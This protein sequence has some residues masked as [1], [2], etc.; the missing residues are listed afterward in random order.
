[1]NTPPDPV[2]QALTRSAMASDLS[3][4]C[5]NLCLAL[6][7]RPDVLQF[8]HILEKAHGDKWAE[9]SEH[10]REI[11][12]TNFLA[13]LNECQR[14]GISPIV[15]VDLPE[16]ERPLPPQIFGR[17]SVTIHK[18]KDSG[19]RYAKAQSIP[20][21]NTLWRI[22]LSMLALVGGPA[23][24]VKSVKFKCAEC[25]TVHKAFEMQG[26]ICPACFAAASE[27]NARQDSQP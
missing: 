24:W 21:G 9:M 23:D 26:E 1:M 14:C 8:A 16:S 10:E 11:A 22:P 3:T 6:G 15:Y 4:A 2:A 17:L 20:T 7:S 27:D 18:K 25:R 12:L 13:V 5:A 19:E